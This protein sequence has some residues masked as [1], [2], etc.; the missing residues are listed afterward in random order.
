[1][2]TWEFFAYI[3]FGIRNFQPGKFPP[4]KLPRGKFSPATF[5]PRKL[6]PGIFPHEFSNLF[7]HC[8]HHYHW[9]YLKGCFVILCFKSAE[10]FTF[11]NI[12]QNEGLSEERKLMKWV[13]IFLVRIFWVAIFRGVFSRGKFDGWEFVGGNLHR[14]IFILYIYSCFSKKYQQI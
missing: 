10:V 4:I 13:G 14:T 12:C 11:V 9:C 1:M 3:F 6:T 5:S 7:F 8:C 2:Y